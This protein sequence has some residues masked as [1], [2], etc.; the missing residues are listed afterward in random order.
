MYAIEEDPDWFESVRVDDGEVCGFHKMNP[1]KQHPNICLR[2]GACGC[3]RPRYETRR[4]S[5]DEYMRI[6]DKKRLAR[7]DEILAEA[8]VIRARRRHQ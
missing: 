2:H 1:G 5:V 6:K 3:R 7:E 4:R 8:Q